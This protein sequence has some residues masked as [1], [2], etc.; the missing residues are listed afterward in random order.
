PPLFAMGPLRLLVFG[1]FN[2]SLVF[3]AILGGTSQY[4]GSFMPFDFAQ[5]EYWIGNEAATLLA[6]VSIGAALFFAGA[7]L[8]VGMAAGVVRTFL[9]DYGFRLTRTESGLRRERGLF[10][11]TDVVIPLKRLQAAIVSTGLV[12][13]HFGWQGL[14]LQSL[15]SDGK[16]GTHHDAAPFARRAELEPIFA[17]MAMPL[18]PPRER[19]VSVSSRSPWHRAV[20][21]ALALIATA[22]ISGSLQPELLIVVALG[23]LTVAPIIWL[24]W[25]ARGYL[26]DGDT[27][28]VRRG[29]TKPQTTILPLPKIQSITVRQS[30]LQRAFGLASLLIGT[31]GAPRMA[32][33]AIPDLERGAALALR[34]TLLEPAP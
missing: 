11:R 24:E 33:L 25:R 19:F 28:F 14:A 2:F 10:T 26:L 17:E 3:L 21:P 5:P 15:G 16:A 22:I 7:L 13:R 23:A 27:L 4:A 9:K 31:A 30:L 6:L 32:P 18:P 1:L 8:M 12:R 34:D 20:L 29:V